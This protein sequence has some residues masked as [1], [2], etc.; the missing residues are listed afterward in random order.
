MVHLLKKRSVPLFYCEL[1]CKLHGAFNAKPFSNQPRKLL[2]G[3]PCCEQLVTAMG[4]GNGELP[5]MKYRLSP[6]QAAV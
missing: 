6:A 3:A 2:S 4:Q 5:L 1:P